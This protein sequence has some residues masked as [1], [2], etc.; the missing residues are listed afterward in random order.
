MQVLLHITAGEALCW[1]HCILRMCLSG[2]A[3]GK[4]QA[5]SHQ[6]PG[7]DAPLA[8]QLTMVMALHKSEPPEARALTSTDSSP[9]R[10]APG[11]AM[12]LRS[13][14]RQDEA[15]CCVG[16]H[17]VPPLTPGSHSRRKE[18]AHCFGRR[19]AQPAALSDGAA[20]ATRRGVRLRGALPVGGPLP[21]EQPTAALEARAAA[22]A[23]GALPEEGALPVLPPCTGASKHTL[24]AAAPCV[25]VSQHLYL[26]PCQDLGFK[27]CAMRLVR[28]SW[29]L[30]G[31]TTL[32]MQL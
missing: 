27:V 11:V 29:R 8:E 28:Q 25:A 10:A 18:M 13:S 20:S 14:S 16:G 22:E 30:A 12:D 7:K 9:S 1:I 21:A 6:K 5:L 32:C 17:L 24:S 19:L 31:M 15:A 3:A 23:D 2:T 26:L 4:W